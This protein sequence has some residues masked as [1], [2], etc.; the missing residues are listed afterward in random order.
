MFNGF[1][2]KHD[3]NLLYI[4]YTT[5]NWL[6]YIRYFWIE[7]LFS[8]KKNNLEGVKI[9]THLYDFYLKIEKFTF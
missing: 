2:D 6:Y 4:V 3:V 7:N 9:K 1:N 5:F 8:L